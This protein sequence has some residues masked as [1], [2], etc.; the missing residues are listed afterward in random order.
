M[1][2]EKSHSINQNPMLYNDKIHW[3]NLKS[4]KKKRKI[5]RSNNT[6]VLFPE[7]NFNTRENLNALEKYKINRIKVNIT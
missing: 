3:Y 2:N 6:M 7:N 1:T 5:G 4:D